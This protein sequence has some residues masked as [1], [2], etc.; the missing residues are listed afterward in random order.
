M[1]RT[2]LAEWLLSSNEEIVNWTTGLPRNCFELTLSDYLSS[3]RDELFLDVD[4]VRRFV[5]ECQ[6]PLQSEL[7]ASHNYHCNFPE[8]EQLVMF[9]D[10]KH[11]LTPYL[12]V[13]AI[14]YIP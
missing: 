12:R 10:L 14:Q 1:V 9:V 4:L 2:F 13:D 8:S 3:C 11:N 6:F 5:W 7:A